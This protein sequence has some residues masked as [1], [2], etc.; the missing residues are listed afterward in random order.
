MMVEFITTALYYEDEDDLNDWLTKE[1][2]DIDHHIRHKVR[3][4]L[5]DKP[6]V[7]EEEIK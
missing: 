4:G 6:R 1:L 3:K 2:N 7:K 5:V